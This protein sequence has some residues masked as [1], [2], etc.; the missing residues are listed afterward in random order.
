MLNNTIRRNKG[1]G[2]FYPNGLDQY[3]GYKPDYA[4][5]GMFEPGY[6][7]KERLIRKFHEWFCDQEHTNDF[8]KVWYDKEGKLGYMYWKELEWIR[9]WV[10]EIARNRLDKSN[11]F[12]RIL[13]LNPEIRVWGLILLI[14]IILI[15]ISYAWFTYIPISSITIAAYSV[16]ILL[17][18][19]MGY[20][21][22][23]EYHN[24]LIG[25]YIGG[26]MN[27]DP[28]HLSTI[29]KKCRANVTAARQ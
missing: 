21:G 18:C 10:S 9:D 27:T 2:W 20:K 8:K 28:E 12:M 1:D 4:S 14:I 24:Y 29:P 23:N 16:G 7:F 11:L 6:R 22:A 19:F 17:M 13:I 15:V 26:D 25:R 5:L 3:Y